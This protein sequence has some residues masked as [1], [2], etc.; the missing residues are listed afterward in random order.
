MTGWMRRAIVPNAPNWSIL[1]ALRGKHEIRQDHHSRHAVRGRNRLRRIGSVRAD[2]D[3]ADLSLRR[4]HRVPRGIFWLRQ[5]RPYAGGWQGGDAAK[6]GGPDRLA[7]FRRRRDAAGHQIRY[8]LQDR[9]AAGD[10][11][12]ADVNLKVVPDLV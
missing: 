8:H 10:D 11:L 2:H 4:R 9:Q 7:L 3:M 5:A 12:P 6:A 1:G